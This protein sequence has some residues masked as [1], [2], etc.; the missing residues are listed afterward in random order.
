[1]P[2]WSIMFWWSWPAVKVTGGGRAEGDWHKAWVALQVK[3]SRARDKRVAFM[4][5]M[6]FRGRDDGLC[7]WIE[8][9]RLRV[10]LECLFW[11]ERTRWRQRR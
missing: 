8:F 1:M 9:G 6:I 10:G 7:G 5:G 4:R 11:G 2:S 3:R